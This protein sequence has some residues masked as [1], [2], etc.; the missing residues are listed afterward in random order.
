MAYM[1]YFYFHLL[2]YYAYVPYIDVFSS[3]KGFRKNGRLGT[4]NITG[5]HRTHSAPLLLGPPKSSGT[6]LPTGNTSSYGDIELH[7]ENIDVV[8]DIRDNAD[9]FWKEKLDKEHEWYLNPVH[10]P[11]SLQVPFSELVK[12]KP[13]TASVMKATTDGTL[14]RAYDEDIS[15]LPLDEFDMDLFKET[16]K[17]IYRNEI[18]KSLKLHSPFEL[19]LAKL[20]QEKLK[21]EEAYL[22]QQKCKAELEETRGPIPRW[23]EMKTSQFTTEH[24]KHNNLLAIPG[25]WEPL[26]D[27]RNSLIQASGRWKDLSQ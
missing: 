19:Q 4:V 23:Y 11:N 7:P 8:S 2:I 12:R 3:T 9:R 24:R 26:I 21:L 25:H 5:H 22:L 20:K 10:R 18:R 14:T 27:Y 15:A 16:D 17:E 1:L 6:H 13:L